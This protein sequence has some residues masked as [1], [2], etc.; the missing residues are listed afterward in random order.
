[1]EQLIKLAD[2]P[3][4]IILSLIIAGIIWIIYYMVKN[5]MFLI[6]PPKNGNGKK[7]EDKIELLTAIKMLGEKISTNDLFHLKKDICEEITK[8]R[9]I[10]RSDI[11]TFLYRFSDK[12]T[13]SNK[14]LVDEIRNGFVSL[15]NKIGKRR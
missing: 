13:K 1:M 5:R 2:Y 3:I 4:T 9:A 10:L 8:D 15:E 14:E 7:I 6:S 11:E 12:I